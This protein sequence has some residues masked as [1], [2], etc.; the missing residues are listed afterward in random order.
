MNVRIRARRF[1][2]TQALRQHVEQCLGL[3]LGRF[4][5]R[6]GQVTV[7][8]SAESV[9]KGCQIDVELRPLKLRVEDRD[10]DRFAAVKHAATAASRSISRALDRER[11]D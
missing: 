11:G 8:F 6:V 7:R 3:V 9:A 5:S 1:E 2:V 10:G 4:G